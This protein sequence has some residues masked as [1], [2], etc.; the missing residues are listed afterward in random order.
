VSSIR[1]WL[2]FTAVEAKASIQTGNLGF[3]LNPGGKVFEGWHMG[4]V[5]GQSL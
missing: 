3:L 2:V 4:L 1:A 5:G